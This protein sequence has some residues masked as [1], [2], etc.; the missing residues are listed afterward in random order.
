MV[1]KKLQP[2]KFSILILTCRAANSDTVTLILGI[3]GALYHPELSIHKTRS[4]ESYLW[5]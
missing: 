4:N 2:A 1:I 5:L 3:S